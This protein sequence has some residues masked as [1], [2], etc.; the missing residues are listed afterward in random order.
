M[1]NMFIQK[2]SCFRVFVSLPF[3]LKTTKLNLFKFKETELLHGACSAK[4]DNCYG[5][6]IFLEHTIT[7]R[8]QG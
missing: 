2:F 4:T 7:K 6:Y 8:Y 1:L 3:K 5:I